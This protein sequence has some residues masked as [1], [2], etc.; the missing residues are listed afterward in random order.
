MKYWYTICVHIL[1]VSPSQRRVLWEMFSRW[2]C[3]KRKLGGCKGNID[4][5]DKGIC[6][7]D[8]MHTLGVGDDI[9]LNDVDS[10][11]RHFPL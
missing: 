7:V 10:V 3:S 4:C 11:V 1:R 9:K 6:V 2:A 5:C 8:M